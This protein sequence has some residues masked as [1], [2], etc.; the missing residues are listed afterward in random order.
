[1]MVLV[2]GT[3][4]H[5]LITHCFL[6]SQGLN[7]SMAPMIKNDQLNYWDFCGAIAPKQLVIC[8]HGVSNYSEFTTLYIGH[9]VALPILISPCELKLVK[10][11]GWDRKQLLE[12]GRPD[13]RFTSVAEILTYPEAAWM[14]GHRVPGSQSQ[15]DVKGQEG[16]LP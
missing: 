7:C 12:G 10:L 1:M 16:H 14:E 4:G 6:S 5:F 9:S 2:D 8:C 3:T 13:L 15:K 11:A